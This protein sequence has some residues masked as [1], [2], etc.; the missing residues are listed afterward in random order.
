MSPQRCH[1]RE[2]WALRCLPFILYPLLIRLLTI[3][4][5]LRRSPIRVGLTFALVH[6][7]ITANTTALAAFDLV[8]GLA[9]TLAG[10][11]VALAAFRFAL[12]ARRITGEQHVAAFEYTVPL[13]WHPPPPSASLEATSD[14]SCLIFLIFLFFLFFLCSLFFIFFLVL[15]LLTRS[16]G[17]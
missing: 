15:C 3:F 13:K 11:I 1:A 14:K 9:P 5:A 2:K 6:A 17:R 8:A 7:R 12:S 10:D 4:I 16:Q